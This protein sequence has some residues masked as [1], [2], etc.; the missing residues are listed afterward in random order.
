MMGNNVPDE[1][2]NDNAV[3]DCESIQN[4]IKSIIGK[5]SPVAKKEMKA[6]LEAANLPTA[7]NKVT[8]IDILNKILAI[9]SE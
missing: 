1:E 7:Y 6:K 5:L 4:E 3:D 2:E 9:V 8:D